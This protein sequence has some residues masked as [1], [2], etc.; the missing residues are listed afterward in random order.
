MRCVVCAH[1]HPLVLFAL[2]RCCT[3]P[4]VVLHARL[5]WRRE[6]CYNAARSGGVPAMVN[7]DETL[8]AAQVDKLDLASPYDG[9]VARN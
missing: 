4:P 5:Y 9:N 2:H 6:S 1:L 3:C 8:V 7:R